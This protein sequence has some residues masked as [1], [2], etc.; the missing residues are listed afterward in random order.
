M[1][2]ESTFQQ[3]RIPKELVSR[4]KETAGANIRT[5]SGEVIFALSEYLEREELAQRNSY[6]QPGS[7]L[8]KRVYGTK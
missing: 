7:L 3:V 4:L 1:Q 5:L 8:A 2:K 6:I